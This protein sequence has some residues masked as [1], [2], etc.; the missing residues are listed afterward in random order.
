M[1]DW[2][3]INGIYKKGYRFSEGRCDFDDAFSPL[4]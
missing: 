4:L 3:D 2:T 1:V